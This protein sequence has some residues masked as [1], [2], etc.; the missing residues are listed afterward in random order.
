MPHTPRGAAGAG[1]AGLCLTALQITPTMAL[2]AQ[3]ERASAPC[4]SSRD[5]SDGKVW[6]SG[7]K[8][9]LSSILRVLFPQEKGNVNI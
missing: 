5:P 2:Q 7:Y 1:R 8:F 4:A 3:G 6:V 9:R